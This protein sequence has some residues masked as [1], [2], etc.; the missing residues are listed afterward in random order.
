MGIVFLCLSC[1]RII[2]LTVWKI[3]ISFSLLEVLTI[4]ATCLWSFNLQTN[5][6]PAFFFFFFSC[7]LAEWLHFPCY[8]LSDEPNKSI[9]HQLASCLSEYCLRKCFL[10]CS[11]HMV[12]SVS[13]CCWLNYFVCCLFNFKVIYC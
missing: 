13:F 9:L 1:E 7:C 8:I 12:M 6:F 3:W 5:L 4:Y 11:L 10:L 2:I